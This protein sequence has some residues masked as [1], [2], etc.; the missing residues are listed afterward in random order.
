MVRTLLSLLR[1]GVQSLVGELRSHKL[2]KQNNKQK[3]NSKG[4]RKPWQSFE[5]GKVTVLH[6]KDP[7]AT[8]LQGRLERARM[9]E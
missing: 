5:Q 4:M 6:K 7:L 2:Q 1:A 8:S 3:N 9:E